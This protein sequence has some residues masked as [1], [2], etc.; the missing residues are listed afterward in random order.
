LG[1]SR[2]VDGSLERF[3]EELEALGRE[4][5]A[6][7]GAADVRQF[8]RLKWL[9]RAA[10]WAGRLSLVCARGPLSFCF[11]VGSLT[12]HLALEAQLNHTVT[13]GAYEGLPGAERMD[14]LRYETLALPLQSATW[15]LAH[16][17]HHAHP[18][19]L[20]RDPDTLHPLFRVHP[21]V[22]WR[23]WH[24]LN[25][26][27]GGLFVFECWGLDYD[28]FLKRLGLR[29]PADRG[30]LKKLACFVA[31]QYVL[32]ALLAWTDWPRV[33]F[34]TLFAVIVRNYVFVALQTGSSV[35]EGISTWHAAPPP[36]LRGRGEHYR[37]QVETS[38]NYTLP[39][40]GTLL[41]G[42]LDRHIEHH[43]WPDLPPERLT[44]LSGRV[45]ALCAKH[46]VRYVAYPSAWASYVDSF[47]YLW[48]LSRP[49]G[50]GALRSP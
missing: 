27:L 43:L 42:G 12:L 1:V 32:F 14:P 29:D 6:Q 23:P 37:F 48:R 15:R 38:K 2:I 22:R 18:S 44:A 24:A 47:R 35:G 36:R 31:Y 25:T 17:I 11:G 39:A 7:V 16:K 9:S 45:R 8:R 50:R 19:V 20:G 3:A 33:L 40:L 5:R 13:H 10:E 21:D 46:G 49:G 34:G 26:V 4:E 30:E 28:A 41:C